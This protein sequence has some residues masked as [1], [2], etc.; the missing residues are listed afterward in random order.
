MC[1]SIPAKL[2]EK[3]G[4]QGKADLE[5]SLIPVN[6]MM[7]PEAAIGD[8]VIVHAGVAIQRYEEQDA[9]ETLALVR[10]ALGEA[11]EAV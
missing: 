2:I 6:L 5:G 9:M 10:E 7:L 8:Y 3:D 4:V 11:P 1:L